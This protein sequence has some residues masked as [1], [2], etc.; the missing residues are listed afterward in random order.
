MTSFLL[1]A[2]P[3]A[4]AQRCQ[5]D[6]D[7]AANQIFEQRNWTYRSLNYLHEGQVRSL[8]I[9]SSLLDQNQRDEIRSYL[10]R[11]QSEFYL[12]S[13]TNDL[14]ARIKDLIVVDRMDCSISDDYLAD[15]R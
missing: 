2:S 12:A 4:H 11:G 9:E 7:Q 15:E 8:L 10:D 3:S 1:L 6:V 14:S 5:Q 13:G